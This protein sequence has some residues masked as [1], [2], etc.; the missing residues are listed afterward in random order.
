M[1]HLLIN[2]TQILFSLLFLAES[3]IYFWGILRVC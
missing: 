1:T 2:S 3:Q